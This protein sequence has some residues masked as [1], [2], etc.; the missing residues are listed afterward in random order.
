MRVKVLVMVLFCSCISTASFA[1]GDH[2]NPLLGEMWSDV[3]DP[4]YR[5]PTELEPGSR[6]RKQLFSMLR[7][8]VSKQAK[9]QVKFA[10]SLK[11]FKNWA[12]FVGETYGPK[13]SLI[14]Y[15]PMG[16]SDAVALWL[17]TRSGWRV[18]DYSVGH[19]DVFWEIWP[20][21]YGTPKR[22]LGFQ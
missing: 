6:L 16:N 4:P 5:Q 18:V 1:A 11:V 14:T 19:S 10:G 20:D 12:F 21:Q 15:S 13:G 3:Y 17:R 8:V 2:E 9:R 22:L 7:P